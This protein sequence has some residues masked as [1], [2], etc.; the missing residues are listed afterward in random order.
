MLDMLI[1]RKTDGSLKF[2]VYRKPTHTDQ[3]LQFESHQPME[4]KMGIIRTLTHRANTIITEEEDKEEEV[5]H[6]K[7]VFSIAGYSKWAWQAPGRRK[8]NPHPNQRNQLRPKGHVTIH[9]VQGI[10]EPISRLIRKARVTAHTKPHTTIRKLLVTP[11]DQNKP[12]DKCRVVHHLTC[13]DYELKHHLN[14]HSRDSSPVGHHMGFH[15][16]KL[17]TDNIKIIDQDS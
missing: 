4:H 9:Y 3:Y 16:H 5:Q 15:Q 12:E 10:T 17:D 11:K 13:Q 8:L 7:K 6:I 1:T 14:E 2:S